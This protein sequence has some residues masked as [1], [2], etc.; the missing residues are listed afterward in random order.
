M[1]FGDQNFINVSQIKSDEHNERANFNSETDDPLQELGVDLNLPRFY[2]LDDIVFAEPLPNISNDEN[3]LKD[4][5][6]HNHI[7][8]VDN[9]IIKKDPGKKYKK[10]VMDI[11]ASQLQCP[12]PNCIRFF[13]TTKLL[14]T[15]IR[16]V[17]CADKQ[18]YICDQCGRGFSARYLLQRHVLVHSGDS[19]E[20][21][22][23]GAK[24]K[25]RTGLTN[26][27]R[28]HQNIRAHECGV[29]KKKFTRASTCAT[30][31][32]FVHKNEH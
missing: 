9:V 3:A 32:K 21:P 13:A 7:T 6:Q 2:K 20:C 11:D 31:V 14:K 29:C 27:L 1:E 17:H 30:H 8:V 25:R 23:C 28:S 4:T 16:K 12:Q 10:Y 15:H 19:V 5:E 26:H 22:V 24:L 18:K